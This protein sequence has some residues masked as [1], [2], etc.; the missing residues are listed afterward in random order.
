MAATKARLLKHDVPVHGTIPIFI[1]FELFA[2]IASNLRFA[3][4]V[5]RNA[6]SKKGVQF[7]N[8]EMIRANY[9]LIDSRETGHLRCGLRGSKIVNDLRLPKGPGRIKNTTTY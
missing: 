2:R 9:L 7:G 8:P 3:S 6:I 1:T 4:L 5:P